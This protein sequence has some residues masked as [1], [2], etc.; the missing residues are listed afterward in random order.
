MQLKATLY[1]TIKKTRE[2]RNQRLKEAKITTTRVC[3]IP[4]YRKREEKKAKTYTI[5]WEALCLTLN[6]EKLADCK[7]VN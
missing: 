7:F 4:D 3:L 1:H 2:A 5:I 6:A